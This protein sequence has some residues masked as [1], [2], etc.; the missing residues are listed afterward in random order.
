MTHRARYARPP[1][2]NGKNLAS[3]EVFFRHGRAGETSH[4]D[5]NL[6]PD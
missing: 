6:A 3:R 1:S 5:A 4:G 2:D